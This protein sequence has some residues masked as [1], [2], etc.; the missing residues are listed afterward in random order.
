MSIGHVRRAFSHRSVYINVAHQLT[1]KD[2]ELNKGN[3]V[4]VDFLVQT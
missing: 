2:L 4:K 1:T 3:L